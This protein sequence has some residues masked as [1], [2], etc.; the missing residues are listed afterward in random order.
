MA[1]L[2]ISLEDDLLKRARVRAAEEGTSVNAVLRTYLED[3]T[4][5]RQVHRAA[6]DDFLRI[7]GEGKAGS[8]GRRWT[9]EELY[10]R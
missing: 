5:R 6:G 4:T 10:S 1:N 3:W 8:G 7:V 9:R 2:T